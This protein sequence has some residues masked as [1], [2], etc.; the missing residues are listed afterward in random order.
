MSSITVRN[1]G[2]KYHN[3]LNKIIYLYYVKF[4]CITKTMCES[5]RSPKIDKA[6]KNNKRM[7]KLLIKKRRRKQNLILKLD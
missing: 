7:E 2:R 6:K 5:C 3:L 1:I 4:C